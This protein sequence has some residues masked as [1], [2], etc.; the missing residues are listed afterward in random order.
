MY[1]FSL[2]Y[3]VIDRRDLQLIDTRSVSKYTIIILFKNHLQ[4]ICLE[5]RLKRNRC[6]K[7]PF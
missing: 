5:I 4:T 1:S 6:V 2:I 7:I 3:W